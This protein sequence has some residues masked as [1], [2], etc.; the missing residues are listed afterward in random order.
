MDGSSIA[1]ETAAALQNMSAKD[2]QELNQFIANE[3][4]KAQIQGTIHGLT[5]TCVASLTP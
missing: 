2:K 3:S 5:D 1:P 4:Q